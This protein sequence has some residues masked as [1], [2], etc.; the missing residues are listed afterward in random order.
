MITM[1]IFLPD[2]G[3]MLVHDLLCGLAVGNDDF[4][5]TLGSVRHKERVMETKNVSGVYFLAFS[6]NSTN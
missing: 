2:N 1:M 3:G 5:N 4:P 6:G